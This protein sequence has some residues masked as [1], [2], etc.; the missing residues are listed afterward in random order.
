MSSS[1][2]ALARP[3][4]PKLL[5]RAVIGLA[6]FFYIAALAGELALADFVDKRPLALIALNAR[7]RNLILATNQLEA[8]PY[9]TVGFIRLIIS[10][11]LFFLLGFW[12]GDR[13][14]S[15]IEK[16]S[17]TYGPLV[18]DGESWFR[19]GSYFFIFA[20]PNTYVCALAGATGVRIGTFLALNAA[21]T[22]ARLVGIR[23][24]GDQIEPV[25]S[26]TVDAISRYRIWVFLILGA[27]V[28]WTVF[29]EFRGSDKGEVSSL[30]QLADDD[31]DGDGSSDEASV[32]EPSVDS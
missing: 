7:N 29:G 6:I 2:S 23:L 1:T 16:R 25:T 31:S 21:G 28:L 18:R 9:Y 27:S 32:S 17:R 12:Y 15:W 13:A 4:P 8:L 19:K 24:V 22:V 10:D 14:I 20:A 3:V 30:L 26:W 5:S 11:P